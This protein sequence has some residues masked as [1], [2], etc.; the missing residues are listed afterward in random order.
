MNEQ[1][2]ASS[3]NVHEDLGFSDA[4]EMLLKADLA[5]TIKQIIESKGLTQTK[6]SELI[7]LSQPKLS[8]LL[9]GQFRGISEIKMMECITRL[10]RDEQIVIGEPLENQGRLRVMNTVQAPAS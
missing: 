6:A 9:R 4:E 3:G 5:S 7:G 8:D 10:G 2:T 1:I